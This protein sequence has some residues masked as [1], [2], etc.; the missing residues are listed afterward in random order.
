MSGNLFNS[1]FR[2]FINCLN[3]SQVDYILVGVYSVIIHGYPRT[4][5]DMDIW[6]KPS[7]PNYFK[8]TKA[9]SAFS[10]SVFDMTEKKFLNPNIEVFRFGVPPFRIDLMTSVLGLEFDKAYEHTFVYEEDG[11]KVNVIQINDLKIA[12]KTSGRH[13]DINDLENL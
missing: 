5:G 2:D 10:M 1:D 3:I 13:K 8:L 4:T 6:V 9:F 7:R 11:L 12:K